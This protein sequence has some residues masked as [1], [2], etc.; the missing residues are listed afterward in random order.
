MA[1]GILGSS[2]FSFL[3]YGDS[4]IRPDGNKAVFS[5]Q[6]KICFSCVEVDDKMKTRKISFYT[7][8]GL[9]VQLSFQEGGEKWW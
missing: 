4:G 1:N 8:S 3:Q 2:S 6:E 5:L 7:I 9:W